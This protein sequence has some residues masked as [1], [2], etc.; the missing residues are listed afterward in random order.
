[1]RFIDVGASIFPLEAG[2]TL[3]STPT[4]WEPSSHDWSD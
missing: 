2:S 4:D 3:D 1:M